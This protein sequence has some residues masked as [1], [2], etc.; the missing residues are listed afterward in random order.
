MK[1]LLLG[2]ITFL[3]ITILPASATAVVRWK[4]EIFEPT[5][6]TVNHSL[7]IAYNV[8]SIESSDTFTVELFENGASKGTQ[9]IDNGR[10]GDSGAF[11]VNMPANGTYS[12]KVTATNH[13]D[14]DATK[15]SNTVTVQVVNGPE[16]TIIHVSNP[17]TTTASTA[18]G[19]AGGT[20]GGGQVAGSQTDGQNKQGQGNVTDKAATTEK[21]NKGVLGAETKGSKKSSW[22]KV[23]AIVLVVLAI[24]YA[25]YLFFRRSTPA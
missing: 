7:N 24:L 17:A 21:G 4:V 2:L 15:D 9:E 11:N 20:N 23:P 6:S 22:W 25:G 16:P 12:Y 18:G 8:Q 14:S 10:G 13:G 5:T 1:R 19:G 3:T